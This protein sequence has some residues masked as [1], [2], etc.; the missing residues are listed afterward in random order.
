MVGTAKPNAQVSSSGGRNT[1]AKMP[2]KGRRRL[3]WALAVV[4][5]A[6]VGASAA[7]RMRSGQ[8]GTKLILG[9]V[10]RGDLI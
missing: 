1:K 9:Q 3:G 10:T 5:I 2:S 8:S 4:L 7:A 6:L